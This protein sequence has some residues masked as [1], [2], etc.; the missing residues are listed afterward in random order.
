MAIRKP[1]VGTKPLNSGI[2]IQRADISR[3]GKSYSTFD[4]N[5]CKEGA[6]ASAS[7]S[8][9]AAA[10]SAASANNHWI[11]NLAQDQ[12]FSRWKWMEKRYKIMRAEEMMGASQDS[13]A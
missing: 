4:D 9:S 8:A 6:A 10:A 5:G 12:V 13:L 3:L 2:L 7:A 1:R 11:K